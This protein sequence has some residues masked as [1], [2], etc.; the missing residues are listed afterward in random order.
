[1]SREGANNRIDSLKNSL[2]HDHYQRTALGSA[3]RFNTMLSVLDDFANEAEINSNRVFTK[4]EFSALMDNSV[5]SLIDDFDEATQDDGS[6]PQQELQ[7][8]AYK[9]ALGQTIA[10]VTT[11]RKGL[12]QDFNTSYSSG[13][14]GAFRSFTNGFVQDDED[15]FGSRVLYDNVFGNYEDGTES[16]SSRKRLSMS[17]PSNDNR[18]V[19]EKVLDNVSDKGIYDQTEIIDRVDIEFGRFH[20]Q[21]MIDQYSMTGSGLRSARQTIRTVMAEGS[22]Y[23]RQVTARGESDDHPVTLAQALMDRTGQDIDSTK[24]ALNLLNNNL[25]NRSST[26]THPDGGYVNKAGVAEFIDLINTAGSRNSNGALTGGRISISSFQFQNETIS[27]ALS[28]KIQR[29][30]LESV[31]QGGGAPLQIDLTLAYPRQRNLDSVQDQDGRYAVGQTNY[32]ILGPNL[33]EALKLQKVK[34]DIQD[35]LKGLGVSPDQIENYVNLNIEFRDKKF[36]PKVYLTDNRAS[37]GTQ[38]LTAPVGTSIN[39]AGSNFET[40]RFVTNS[41]TNDNDLSSARS[42]FNAQNITQANSITQSLLYRQIVDSVNQE[43]EYHNG[44]FNRSQGNTSTPI[45]SNQQGSQVGFAGDIYQHLKNTLDFAHTTSFGSQLNNP[46]HM[47]MTLDQAFLLQIGSNSYNKQ[48]AGEMGAETGIPYSSR[49][50][51]AKEYQKQQHKLFDLLITDR[52]SVVVD[53][54]NYKEQ[55]LKPLIDKI[56]FKDEKGNYLNA[57]LVSNFEKQGKNLNILTGFD[58]LRP[59]ENA[60]K[61]EYDSSLSIMFKELRRLGFTKDAGFEESDLK[62]IIGLASGNIEMA[63]APRQ[64]AKEA[65]LVQYGDTGPQLISY[66]QGSSNMGLYSLGINSGKD[67]SYQKGDGNL[68]NTEMGIMLGRRDI[69][70][71]LSKATS[72]VKMSN[73]FISSNNI[74]GQNIELQ[75]WILNEE[76]E[77]YELRLAQRHLSVTWNQLSQGTSIND[78]RNKKNIG[79]SSWQDNVNTTDLAILK[80]RL[81]VMGKDLGLSS[82][83]FKIEERYGNVSGKGVTS[84]NI[85]I[86]L[87]QA[88]SSGGFMQASSKLP[89]LNFELSVLQGPSRGNGMFSDSANDGNVPGFVYF[90]DKNQ[91]IGNGLFVNESGQN[92]SVLGRKEYEDDFVSDFS[93]GGRINLQTGQSAHMSSLDIVPQLFATLMGEAVSRFGSGASINTYN[94]LSVSEKQNLLLNYVSNILTGHTSQ[95]DESISTGTNIKS[96]LSQIKDNLDLVSLQDL[97]ETINRH[98]RSLENRSDSEALQAKDPLERRKSNNALSESLINFNNNWFHRLKSGV[99]LSNNEVFNYIS[100]LNTLSEK[101]PQ[102]INMI[103]KT[104]YKDSNS[105]SKLQSFKDF[106][107]LLF[108][109]FLQTKDDRT[110]GGQQGFYRTI[111]MGLGNSTLDKNTASLMFDVDTESSLQNLNAYAR[112]KPLEYNPLTNIHDV[113][114]RSIASKSTSLTKNDSDLNSI[115]LESE[116][117]DL[118]DAANLRLMS[119]IGIGNIMHRDDFIKK[120]SDGAVELAGDQKSI[121]EAI[122]N[123]LKAS[124]SDLTALNKA[125]ETYLNSIQNEFGALDS[126]DRKDTIRLNFYTGSAKKLSQL[127]QRIK[128]AMGARPMYQY[129][130]DAQMALEK[131][132]SLNDLSKGYLEKYRNP[133]VL[134]TKQKL[135]RLLDEREQLVKIHGE[136][137]TIIKSLDS[138]IDDL[139][140]I[141]SKAFNNKI[142]GLGAIFSGRIKSVLNQEQISFITKTKERL[143]NSIGD[144]IQQGELSDD[145]LDE[146]IR[147]EVL[148]AG[149]TN[150]G[151]GKMISGSDHMN[152]SIALIQLSGTYNDTFSANPLYGTVYESEKTYKNIRDNNIDIYSKETAGVYTLGMKEGQYETRRK[153]VKGSKM[154]EGGMELLIEKDDIV[155]QNKETGAFVHKRKVNGEWQIVGQADEKRNLT[156][157]RNLIDNNSFSPVGSP[158]LASETDTIYAREGQNSINYI[159][160]VDSR[161]GNF[162]NNEYLLDITTLTSQDPSSG[163]RV[164]GTDTSALV[165]GVAMFAGR[166]KY[167]SL[168]NQQLITREMNLFENLEDQIVRSYEEGNLGGSLKSYLDYKNETQKVSLQD[169]RTGYAPLSSSLHGLYNANNFKSFFWSHGATI[170]K[171]QNSSG[172]NFMLDNLFG[173]DNAQS[174]AKK[175]TASLLLNFGTNFIQETEGSSLTTLKRSLISEIVKGEFGS[176]YQKLAIG[177]SQ[178][179]ASEF[180]TVFN[181]EEK[182]A[183]RNKGEIIQD[184]LFDK[185]AG[186]S[187]FNNIQLG[188]LN[189]LTSSQLQQ[190]LNGNQKASIELLNL[191][192]Q[193]IIDPVAQRAVNVGGINFTSNAD[194][195]AT[196][197]TTAVDFMHQLSSQGSKMSIPSDIDFDNRKV[198]QVLLNVIGLGHNTKDE[199]T[200]DIMNFLS[201]V[202]SDISTVS[203]FADITFAYGKDPTGTQSIAKHEAQHLITPYLGDIKKYQEGGKLSNLQHTVAE[204]AALVTK[205]GSGLIFYDQMAKAGFNNKTAVNLVNESSDYLFTSFNKQNYL[206]FYQSGMSKVTTL[207]Y[208]KEYEKVNKGLIKGEYDWAS[209]QTIRDVNDRTQFDSNDL[210]QIENSTVSSHYKKVAEYVNLYH[211]NES[212]LEKAKLVDKYL[213]MGGDRFAMH[214]LD[215]LTNMMVLENS[216]YQSDS[217]KR[218]GMD[219][220]SQFL[221]NMSNKQMF[222]SIPDVNFDMQNGEIIAKPNSGKLISTILPSAKDMQVL[223]AEY[224]GFVDPI[225]GHYKALSSI[226]VPGTVANTAFEKIRL[227]AR[228]NRAIILTTEE[229]KAF[230]SVLDAANLMPLELEKAIGGA[231]TQE[232]FAGK[233]K[234]QGFTATG[235]GNLLMPFGSVVASQTKLDQAGLNSNTERLNSIRSSNEKIRD[236]ENKITADISLDSKNLISSVNF[237]M[238][239]VNN[240]GVKLQD[241]S[242][243][244]PEGTLGA[245]KPRANLIELKGSLDNKNKAAT[246]LHELI[247]VYQTQE[248]IPLWGLKNQ[249]NYADPSV[250]QSRSKDSNLNLKEWQAHSIEEQFRNVLEIEGEESAYNY[251]TKLIASLESK[252]SSN[253]QETFKSLGLTDQLSEEYRQFT[254]NELST[255]NN[256]ELFSNKSKKE[257]RLTLGDSL[258]ISVTNYNDQNQYNINLVKQLNTNKYTVHLDLISNDFAETKLD[259][260]NLLFSKFV[261]DTLSYFNDGVNV[262]EFAEDSNLAIKGIFYNKSKTSADLDLFNR[263]EYSTAIVTSTFGDESTT[264]KMMKSGD[265]SSKNN[266]NYDYSMEV[267]ES[268]DKDAAVKNKLAMTKWIRNTTK[269]LGQNNNL[270][271]NTYEGDGN[272]DYRHKMF[273]KAGFTPNVNNRSNLVYT[274]DP[275]LLNKLNTKVIE[276]EIL[277]DVRSTFQEENF[278]QYDNAFLSLNKNILNFYKKQRSAEAFGISNALQKDFNTMKLEAIQTK[279]EILKFQEVEGLTENDKKAAFETLRDG[280]K[281]KRDIAYKMARINSETGQ[282]I[283]SSKEYSEKLLSPEDRYIYHAQALNYDAMLAEVMLIGD[284]AKL[285]PLSKEVVKQLDNK[286]KEISGIE[287]LLNSFEDTEGLSTFIGLGHKSTELSQDALFTRGVIEDGE[288]MVDKHMKAVKS[289]GAS[290]KGLKIPKEAK[291]AKIQ[292]ALQ[293]IESSIEMYKKRSEDMQ[294]FSAEREVYSMQRDADGKLIVDDNVQRKIDAA[295]SH[296]DNN[297]RQIID[298]LNDQ[299][300]RLLAGEIN[301][302]DIRNVFEDI[303]I[304]IAEHDRANLYIAEVFRPPTPGGT[305]P[306]LHTYRIMQ[307]VQSLNQ[308]SQMLSDSR[309][310]GSQPKMMYSTER[311]Q[312]AT[313]LAALGVTTFGGGDFDGDSYTAIFSQMEPTQKAI[314]NYQS[315]V[316]QHNVVISNLYRKKM[317]MTSKLSNFPRETEQD[318]KRI[319]DYKNNINAIDEAISKKQLLLQNST[320]EL[321]QAK[322]TLEQQIQ[323]GHNGLQARA[324]K[325]IA[326]YMGI[327]ESFFVQQ[328]EVMFDAYGNAMVDSDGNQKT[329]INMDKTYDADSLFVFM[330]QGYKLMEG[331]E[332]SGGLAINL[333]NNIDTLLG[334]NSSP[335]AFKNGEFLDNLTKGIITVEGKISN[336]SPAIGMLKDRVAQLQNNTDNLTSEQKQFVNSLKDAPIEQYKAYLEQ[337]NTLSK[338][339]EKEIAINDFKNKELAEEARKDFNKRA[340]INQWIGGN[341]YSAITS[342]STL[343]KFMTQGNGMTLTEGTFDMTLKTLGKAGG[344]VLGKTYNTIIGTT[345]QDAPVIT[346]GRQ[347]LEDSNLSQATKSEFTRQLEGDSEYV[348]QLRQEVKEE[349][350]DVN[351]PRF[352]QCVKQKIEDQALNKFQEYQE[353]TRAAVLKSEGT[354]GFMKNIHQLLR[355]S[356]KLKDGDG[357]LLGQLK[358][359]SSTYD[360]LSK[361]IV[362][363][364]TGE[365]DASKRTEL[366]NARDQIITGMASKLGPGPGLKSLIDLDYLTNES[367]ALGLSKN[368]FEQRFLTNGGIDNNRQMLLEYSHSMSEGSLTENERNEL[369]DPNTIGEESS[370]L[371]KVA[372]N[373]TAKNISNMVTS[374]R[375]NATAVEGRSE[376]L[377]NFALSHKA[378]LATKN[379]TH[380]ISNVQT[381][382]NRTEDGIIDTEDNAGLYIRSKYGLIEEETQSGKFDANRQHKNALGAHLGIEEHHMYNEDGSVSE[383]YINSLKKASSKLG[384]SNEEYTL[385]FDIH[386][387][388]SKEQVEGLFGKDGEKMEQFTIMNMMRKDIARSMLDGRLPGLSSSKIINENV[389]TEVLTTMAQLASTGK[390]D[391]QGIDIFSGMYKGVMGHLLEATDAVV[392]YKDKGTGEMR[393][394]QFS[395]MTQQQKSA[396]MTKLIYQTMLGSENNSSSGFNRS[397][398]QESKDWKTFNGNLIGNSVLELDE[399]GRL[400]NEFIDALDKAGANSSTGQQV[401]MYEAMGEE[402]LRSSLDNDVQRNAILEQY[403]PNKGETGTKESAFYRDQMTKKVRAQMKYRQEQD[404]KKYDTARSRHKFGHGVLQRSSFMNNINTSAL[405]QLSTDTSANALDLFVPLALTMVGSAISEGSVD[406]DQLMQLGGAT[407]TAFQ[408][409][410]T[411]TIDSTSMDSTQYKKR[412]ASAQAVGGIFKFKNALAQN[413]DENVGMAVAQIAV[414]ETTAIAFNAIATPWLS[415]QI[416]EKG[417]GVKHAPALNSLDMRKYAASQQLAGNLGASVISAISSTLISGLLMNGVE[418]MSRSLGDTIQSFMPAV[419]A[420]NAVNESISKRRQQEAAFE[421]IQTQT[422][423]NEEEV[424]DY[425]VM[426]S[427]SYD[428]NSYMHLADLNEPQ[429]IEPSMDGSLT[430][431]LL[432]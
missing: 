326:N 299:K 327:D 300:S 294:A 100:D 73:D 307:G 117:R 87:N 69:N 22:A 104:S 381:L 71:N 217:S 176:H 225:I 286:R 113:L 34:E 363:N 403:L 284:T 52:A 334:H 270:S 205:T 291:N 132:E 390:L 263:G 387:E 408:Y 353:M 354:Q 345:F 55:V 281:Q 357:N 290:F 407:F 13:A 37:I 226:F 4:K 198:Q 419:N 262:F 388:E 27:A 382:K 121:F 233:N 218:M 289:I 255:T 94:N 427:S 78:P 412:L 1:M 84:I 80:N 323:V 242:S 21:S 336:E 228:D 201:G 240:K 139:K 237:L 162:A 203:I 99:P 332:S 350:I 171:A 68:T 208:V 197:I 148:K 397:T 369:R 333:M 232:A 308:V 314:Q 421:D 212:D 315:K 215:E 367:D 260:N 191:V 383:A 273:S 259:N 96:A 91:I 45:L 231:R 6:T 365:Q 32:G 372:R 342:D 62:Q 285:V 23:G 384:I 207:D 134:A 306:R 43:R 112:F 125:R 107:T 164:E 173:V 179:L 287:F 422:D 5:N 338:E 210:S 14:T 161:E 16:L 196:I 97:N 199:L 349:G 321:A 378:S 61:S 138:Q 302:V 257:T 74:L 63:K 81:E 168:V 159:Y 137:N 144:L 56:Y 219:S 131:G 135:E 361:Q 331:I 47:F 344:E 274:N 399:H 177:H 126:D 136:D 130:I 311:G 283:L 122:E 405:N 377:K 395:T 3:V 296:Y 75:Q 278:Q 102:L 364:D 409:A 406:K 258:K 44:A 133:L 85:S 83:A 170:L 371:L 250:H 303:D 169:G 256:E 360:D 101:S 145:V 193:G 123:A 41:F 65:A 229:Y 220:T 244:A 118:G 319:E 36:H 420:V 398:S 393:T 324:R 202:N 70:P 310:T 194:R 103:M 12:Y 187:G 182:R 128:N 89:K 48:L 298:F 234:Y 251:L 396:Y 362:A 297:T 346:Y 167:N 316:D 72:S 428:S 154:G 295:S 106:Q 213:M 66:Y 413:G 370:A 10:K 109:S 153:S 224:S 221:E 292:Y 293:Q 2:N 33:I 35:M 140:V 379:S 108:G 58:L 200:E 57:N 163:Q 189:I 98:S 252:D 356:I 178:Q 11:Q 389:G 325:Q 116:A 245:Y 275:E 249:S 19:G 77:E 230:Q 9:T 175:L 265:F 309:E 51:Q 335:E 268:F 18:T 359:A 277:Y 400:G 90:V 180:N 204:L 248:D 404:S 254:V 149:L 160:G 143:E 280:I 64:H 24:S 355:D 269:M 195:Q 414:Q 166:I 38:N 156:T 79:S 46:L 411:G 329:G 375:M 348:S 39:Q 184:L 347:M 317:E 288:G 368:D 95:I 54:K 31:L 261:S 374:F 415:K 424:R 15:Y 209:I 155:T 235:I 410:R 92:V 430:I 343:A 188:A 141:G 341:L 337:F 272:Q 416:A 241:L 105:S 305:D 93:K 351:D 124:G 394:M 227:S 392:E 42:S 386:H 276:E 402:Y 192:R 49:D 313:V 340:F 380:S 320:E 17:D 59:N 211:S 214:Q 267:N 417:L 304:K 352:N 376:Q 25:G 152:Y 86:D 246:L 429:D 236:L 216:K 26:T 186:Q 30:V 339:M 432:G 271:V 7:N 282:N 183:G 239:A 119:S 146:L 157:V 425:M 88:L 110:Y 373:M 50:I 328:G 301:D 67:G 206:G 114:Y 223:G 418:S 279:N 190:V 151:L 165:K 385:M 366:I 40:M 20:G 401:E 158:S 391:S 423:N 330:E 53:T 426:T 243:L 142:S 318:L 76:E 129:S 312:T 150:K 358:E 111:L 247:H 322:R 115:L 238:E 222:F 127:P 181:N 29:H 147:V 264:L 174:N 266:N 431:D 120:G 253:I 8:R 60:T 172:N 28:D 82:S 185:I